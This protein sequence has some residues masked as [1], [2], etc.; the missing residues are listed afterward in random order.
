MEFIQS[1]NYTHGRDGKKVEILVLHWF[2][3]GT[4]D[5]AIN[6]FKNP[7]RQASAHYLVSDN[8]I[9]QMVDENDTAWHC[10]VFNMNQKSIGIENDAN[11][12]KTLSEE[13]YQ[14]TGRLIKKICQRHN[15]PIDREHIKGHREIKSTQCPGTI[16]IDKLI[17]IAKGDNMDKLD[18]AK[19]LCRARAGKIIDNEVNYIISEF[20]DKGRPLEDYASN[21][22]LRDNHIPV[23]WR[24]TMGTDTPISEI[25]HWQTVFIKNEAEIFNLADIWYNDHVK[26]LKDKITELENRPPEI[27]EVIKEVI[28]ETE[29]PVSVLTYEDKQYLTD[30]V[31]KVNDAKKLRKNQTI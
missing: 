22:I 10:G 21:N 13:S 31:K 19:A 29:K 25:D 6:S 24:A 18:V 28:K 14:T 16:D 20:I 12:N 17:N 4:I 1:P 8:R 7:E 27:K 11:P 30:F 26:P 5:S 3:I 9:V 2:G 23:L 15:I